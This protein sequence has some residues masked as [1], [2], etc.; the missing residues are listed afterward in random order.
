MTGSARE[1]LSALDMATP[2][3]PTFGSCVENLKVRSLWKQYYYASSSFEMYVL[4]CRATFRLCDKHVSACY[5]HQIRCQVTLTLM[6]V[7][8]SC[9]QSNTKLIADLN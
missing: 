8:N 3:L 5:E 7:V 1:S 2:L 4:C 6:S 9:S